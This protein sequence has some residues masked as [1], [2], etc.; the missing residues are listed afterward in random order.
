MGAS[1]AEELLSDG[2][3]GALSI[4]WASE[5]FS[6]VS[7]ASSSLNRHRV[8]HGRSLRYGTEENSLKVFLALD[9]L[10]WAVR[11][12]ESGEAAA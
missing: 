8:L 5:S 12:H 10:A 2:T 4:L 11:G 1:A 7:P 9:Q 6:S 3:L